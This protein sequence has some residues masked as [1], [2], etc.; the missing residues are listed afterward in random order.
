MVKNDFSLHNGSL[1]PPSPSRY[2]WQKIKDPRASDGS[3]IWVCAPRNEVE[4]LPNIL[5]VDRKPNS[6]R[7]LCKK[8][9]FIF[10]G[11]KQRVKEH[12]RQET[13]RRRPCTHAMTPEEQVVCA[14]GSEVSKE[15]GSEAK[16]SSPTSQGMPVVREKKRA[17]LRAASQASKGPDPGT[18][19]KPREGCSDSFAG[20]NVHRSQN[21]VPTRHRAQESPQAF[22]PAPPKKIQRRMYNKSQIK[23]LIEVHKMD[24]ARRPD[25]NKLAMVFLVFA[26]LPVH[27]WCSLSRQ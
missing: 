14:S 27:L 15:Y 16:R 6:C 4:S 12:L 24:K 20:V 18:S 5:V 13:S 7:Y 8:C 9:H 26:C 17:R 21:G 2:A 22:S 1:P 3:T 11:S 25:H 19:L 23:R 10:W